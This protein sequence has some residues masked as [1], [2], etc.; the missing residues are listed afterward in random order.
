MKNNHEGMISE[1][2]PVVWFRNSLLLLLLLCSCSIF[3]LDDSP[4][5]KSGLKAL[6]GKVLDIAKEPVIGATVQV[7]GTNIFTITDLDGLFSF[8]RA[9][10]EVVLVVTYVGMK[11][12]E[13]PASKASLI[14]LEEDAIQLDAV[15][16]IGYQSKIKANL[17]TSISQ[18]TADDVLKSRPT[19]DPIEMLQG[20]IPGASISTSTAQPGQSSAIEI[21]GVSSINS[22][23]PFIVVDGVPGVDIYTLNPNNIE[24]VTLIKDAAGAAIYGAN[25]ASGVL[26][27][28]TKSGKMGSKMQIDYK[29]NYTFSKPSSLQNYNNSYDNAILANVAY[30]NAGMQPKYSDSELELFRDPSVTAVP[31][32]NTWLY[33][34]DTDWV[35][36]MFNNAS[37]QSHSI[38]LSGGSESTSYRVSGGYISDRGFF[39][40]WGPDSNDRLNLSTNIQAKLLKKRDHKAEDKLLL[41]V[42]T[43]Y[44]RTI[45]K[46]PGRYPTTDVYMMGPALPLYDPNGNY[47]RYSNTSYNPIQS[48]KESGS[49]TT[50]GD[51]FDML[52]GLTYNV[53]KNLSAE[54]RG[55]YSLIYSKY[56]LFN[57]AFGYYGPN[58]LISNTAVSNRPN[59]ID[60]YMNYQGTATWRFML[61]YSNKWDNHDFSMIAGNEGTYGDR[62]QVRIGRTDI[63]GNTIPS[64]LLGSTNNMTNTGAMYDESSVSFFTRASYNYN[65]RYL[66]EA[67]LR[68]DASS[69]FSSK[70][71]WG[72]FPGVSAGWRASNEEF[73]Q[74]QSLVSDLKLRASWGQLGNKSGI[75]RTD[76][77]VNYTLGGYYPFAGE[78]G[79]WII[80][81]NIPM[82]DRTWETVTITN[83][84]LDVAF[85]K[86]KLYFIGELFKKNNS[87]MIIPIEVPNVIGGTISAGNYG[88]MNTNGWELTG[89]WKQVLKS[90]FRYDLSFTLSRSKDML[91]DYGYKAADP[92]MGRNNYIEGYPIWSWFG[93]EADGFYSSKED[94]E[95]KRYA[96]ASNSAGLGD[97]KY[98]DQNGDGKLNSEDYIFLGSTRQPE[99][100]YGINMNASYKG[101]DLNVTFQGQLGK[102]TYLDRNSV[103]CHY[104][105]TSVNSFEIHKDYWREDNK[106]AIFPRPY[107]NSSWNYVTSSHWMYNT[108][109]IRLKNLSLGYTVPS[110]LVR[111]SG[112]SNLRVFISGQNLFEFSNMLDGYDPENPGRVYPIARTVSVGLSLSL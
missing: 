80:P 36:M 107:I 34:A 39:N 103:E 52:L 71:R 92:T 98:V 67:V 83:V 88:A 61:N 20:I 46:R 43:D 110:K 7:K 106:D 100:N 41:N 21:R 84:G 1:Y 111:K 30:E 89:G 59:S 35:S 109:F 105:T 62:R 16:A 56:T 91:T 49:A 81:G 47:A 10:D 8:P 72:Y 5:R 29:G 96:K 75:G 108:S 32:G 11:T 53:T 40:K 19:N 87:D 48:M 42:K 33:Y 58:G 69:R 57:R 4:G 78:E 99:Y 97:L 112:L 95:N 28:T 54:A 45:Q 51:R 68:T 23:G 86:N 24:S 6:R 70:N 64:F 93:Y 13:V 38:S 12:V 104:A 25:A 102:N 63:A 31:N 50:T 44:T 22:A 15:V 94:L 77:L 85:F 73:M 79:N 26:L 74:N 90:G 76:H 101:F 14:I 66:L 27:V 82:V 60:E 17:T 2:S 9:S 55:S 18:I 3:A 37:N 65:N